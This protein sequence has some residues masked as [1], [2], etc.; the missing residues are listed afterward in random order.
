MMNRV[1]IDVLLY[2]NICVEIDA[3]SK[4]H[5]LIVL[6]YASLL[7]ID[8]LAEGPKLYTLYSRQYKGG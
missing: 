7:F 3:Y 2:V 4:Y 8:Y 1:N 5:A 6:L